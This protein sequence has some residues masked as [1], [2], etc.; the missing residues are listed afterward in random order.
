MTQDKAFRFN[1]IR[2]QPY[3]ETGEFAVIGIVV[4]SPQNHQFSYKLIQTDQQRSRINNFFNPLDHGILQSTLQRIEAELVRI[5]NLIPEV[6]NPTAL[7]EELTR[8]RESIIRF[9]SAGVMS[10]KQ[11]QDC[12]DDLFKRYIQRDYSIAA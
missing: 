11:I 8:E 3:V 2:F 5:Q 9:S 4:Y 7:Y 10:G 1:F 6:K 12:I